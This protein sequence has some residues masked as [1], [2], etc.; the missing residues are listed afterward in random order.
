MVFPISGKVKA[1]TVGEDASFSTFS[2]RDCLIKFTS[3]KINCS[4]IGCYYLF[5]SMSVNAN[6]T[7]MSS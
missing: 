2:E 1:K 5:T 3:K 7:T 6:L 4:V